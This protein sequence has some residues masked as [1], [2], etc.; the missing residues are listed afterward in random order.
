MVKISDI[1][2]F[3]FPWGAKSPSVGEIVDAAKLAEELGFYSV[4]LSTHMT[5][6]SGWLFQGINRDVLD[7]LVVVPAIAAATTTIRI[8]F[9]SIL[10][11]LMPPYQWAKYLATLD[12]MS[13]GRLIVGASMGWW[14]E[15]FMAAGVDRTKRGKLFDEQLEV[16]TSLWTEETTTFEGEHYQLENMTLEPK[17]VQKPYPPIWIGA[18]VKSIGR[19]ARYGEYILALWPSEEEA[20]NLWVPR[21]AEEGEKWGRNPKL[22]SF[23]FAYM[24]E[25]DDDLQAQLPKLRETVA[26]SEDPPVDPMDVTV[27]GSPQRCAARI[28]SLAEAG[29]SHF[30]LEFRFRGLETVSFGMKQME[31]FAEEVAPLL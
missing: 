12:V 5:M 3:L 14:E 13:G 22:V 24:A 20:R 23:N 2:V 27:S 9:N 29:V 16:I 4:T 28:N 31:R 19:T 7:A 11:P 26:F 1:S 8:G 25:N 17:P 6:P 21:L 18:G 10:L 30:V 15:D